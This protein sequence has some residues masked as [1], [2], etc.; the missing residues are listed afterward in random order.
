MAKGFFYPRRMELCDAILDD[1]S[2]SHAA[3]SIGLKVLIG[4]M[5]STSETAWM[6]ART[7]A[8]RLNLHVDTVRGNLSKLCKLGYLSRERR[9]GQTTIYS[10][11]PNWIARKT[12]RRLEP[13][14]SGRRPCD[15][16]RPH[17]PNPIRN[18]D[19]NPGA[20]DRRDP[21]GGSFR[22]LSVDELYKHHFD[23]TDEEESD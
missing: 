14:P 1:P 10:M 23:Q 22:Q 21:R 6:S 2:L 15:P 3:K 20:E 13:A 17:R 8:K 9:T 4:Y 18:P 11:G 16:R 5:N 19:K 12:P 7:L